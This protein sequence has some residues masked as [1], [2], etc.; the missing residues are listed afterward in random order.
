MK[1]QTLQ[2]DLWLWF[3][4][5]HI[6]NIH[7]GK[8]CF[9]DPISHFYV[10]Y[11]LLFTCLKKWESLSS[12]PHANENVRIKPESGTKYIAVFLPLTFPAEWECFK[13]KVNAAHGKRACW[14]EKRIFHFFCHPRETPLFCGTIYPQFYKLKS[15]MIRI[16]YLLAGLG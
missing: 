7:W 2:F 16:N 11:T 6:S 3:F 13:S 8:K 5:F 1:I 9:H 15:R 10:K 14:S 4:V 12:I